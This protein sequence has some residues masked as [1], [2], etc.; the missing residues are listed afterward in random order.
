M[1]EIEYA[2]ASRRR[3][4]APILL[5]A[6]ALLAGLTIA[7][8]FG[9]VNIPIR[10]VIRFLT[11]AP[12]AEASTDAFIF[13][14]VRLPRVV[15]GALVGASLA[16]AGVILQGLFKNP[17]AEPY[18]V[19]VSFGGALGASIVILFGGAA[20]YFRFFGVPGAAIAGAFATTFL[21]YR[22]ARVGSRVPI[23][24]LILSGVAISSF[25]S[26]VIS[27]MMALKST[28]LNNLI[29]WL[30]GGLSARNWN[31]VLMVLPFMAAGFPLAMAYARDLNAV[32]LGDEK[33]Y[34][35]GIDVENT[36][37]ILIAASAMLAGAAVSVS[38][39]IG[40]VGLIIPH[41]VRLIIGPDHRLLMPCS[42]LAGALFLVFADTLARLILV[43]QE[44]PVGIVTALFGAP[45]FIYLLRSGKRSL[46]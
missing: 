23:S 41:V 38:G 42:A 10:S 11:E 4:Y 13:W 9:A 43:P 20:G 12:P 32:S 28:D 29:F 46:A 5:L 44:L 21:V 30:M 6:V 34:Q 40:F 3:R 27:L 17:M 8:A 33:A 36:K 24:T 2:V 25:M 31:H 7:S 45:F 16:L 19:G 39:L 14:Q 22:I 18:V 26:A 15:L 37:R 35:L 1:R